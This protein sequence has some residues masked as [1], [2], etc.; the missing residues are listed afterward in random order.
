VD[1]KLGSESVDE[2]V[3]EEALEKR[4]ELKKMYTKE[5]VLPDKTGR[6]Q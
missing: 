6:F 5:G 2:L 1:I 3:I 4:E